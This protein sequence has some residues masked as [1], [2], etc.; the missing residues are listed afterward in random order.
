SRY[1]LS[2]CGWL[3][4]L[5]L[6]GLAGEQLALPLRERLLRAQLPPSWLLLAT[7]GSTCSGDQALGDGVRDDP[8]EEVHAAD[9]IVIARD[10]VVD[11]IGVAV[12]VK[13]R[14]HRDAELFCLADGDVLLLGV[15]DPDRARHSLHVAN[16]TK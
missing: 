16:A 4:G 15:N 8:G 10:R 1:W 14:D 13:D 6:R 12:G 5:R 11:L 7:G 2:G 3:G 9:G